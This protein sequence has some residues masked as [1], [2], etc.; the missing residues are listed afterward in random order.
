MLGQVNQRAAI[1]AWSSGVQSET[2]PIAS[3]HRAAAAARMQPIGP[4]LQRAL[5]LHDQPAGA[6]QGVAGDQ[7]QAAEQRERAQPVEGAAGVGAVDHLDALDEGAEHHALGEGGD[8]SS[9]R[10]RPGPTSGGCVRP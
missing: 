6:E 8:Q 5:G 4:V 2:T 9:R 10:R 3:Q 1:S 7:R